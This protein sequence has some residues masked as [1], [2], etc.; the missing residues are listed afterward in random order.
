MD[1]EDRERKRRRS[2]D[3]YFMQGWIYEEEKWKII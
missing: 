2:I 3:D 1:T